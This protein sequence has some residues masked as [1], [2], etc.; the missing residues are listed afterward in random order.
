ML[1]AQSILAADIAAGLAARLD[2]GLNWQLTDISTDGGDLVG[3]QSALGDSV[4][5]DVGW[6]TTPRIGLFRAGAFDPSEQAAAGSRRDASSPSCRSTRSPPR[7]S[8]RRTPRRAAPRSRT[9][10]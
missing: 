1:F 7:W 2:A 6:T 3:K 8:S 9:R 5:V 10:T 4:V